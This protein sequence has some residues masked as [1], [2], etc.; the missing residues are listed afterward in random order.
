MRD[1]LLAAIV[2]GSIP[3][4]FYRPHIGVL[5][6]AWISYMT[7]HRFTWGFAYDFRFAMVIA[8]VTIAAWALSREPKR[9]P[10][11][12]ALVFLVAFWVWTALTT[13]LALF[14]NSA[15]DVWQD[16]TKKIL[17]NAVVTAALIGSRK[18][19]DALIWVIVISIG[20]FGVK[21][22]LFT[23]ATGGA[24][25]IS[26]A[27]DSYIGE[28]NFLA[29][30]LIVTI[31][32]MRYLQLNTQQRFVRW[33]ITGAMTLCVIS[34]LGS[35]SRGA[36]LGLIALS[37]F[38]LL[39]SRKKLLISVGLVSVL[40]TGFAFMPQHW[41]ARMATIVTYEEDNSAQSRLGAWRYALQVIDEHPLTGLGFEAFRG[42]ERASGQGYTSAHSI[43]F[44][45]LG[46]HG[47]IGVILYFLAG[48]CT[49][50]RGNWVIRKA[51]GH[52]DLRW[53]QD[54][55]RMIQVS[56][57]VFA[58]VGAFLN[59]TYFELFF[60]LVGIM[61]VTDHLVRRRVA[62]DFVPLG[63]TLEEWEGQRSNK[64]KI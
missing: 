10:W 19:I 31:P 47:V 55:A 16:V 29:A 18:R 37:V 58:C 41:H 46:E 14:P 25:R 43:Y 21:G 35:Y 23:L 52:E 42:N 33:G 13:T 11:N 45:I 26:G 60:Q 6:W 63:K 57:A 48:I 64:S 7:P 4:I 62:N 50:L 1:I 32:L 39:R 54:L 49:F 5:V 2:F 36:F 40:F 28:N 12:L 61:A 51:Q 9:V 3:F 38:M 56:L 15:E 22:G 27:P 59:V 30:A 20:F 8:A 34:A 17:M 24:Y 53:A 44:Q